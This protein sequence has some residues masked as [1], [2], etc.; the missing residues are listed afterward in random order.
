MIDLLIS[1]VTSIAGGPKTITNHVWQK[2][3][4]IWKKKCCPNE[5]RS[6]H[7]HTQQIWYYFPWQFNCGLGTSFF[8]NFASLKIPKPLIVTQASARLIS[9]INGRC[10]SN[11]LIGNF[12]QTDH[13]DYC[14]LVRT[15]RDIA[16]DR[17]K[18][19]PS[20]FATTECYIRKWTDAPEWTGICL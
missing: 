5:I 18:L 12:Q 1:S 13:R 15:V 8:K 6:Y 4:E 20:Y 11:P 2:A 17:P 19:I 14:W 3:R 10:L 16:D 9:S 7:T